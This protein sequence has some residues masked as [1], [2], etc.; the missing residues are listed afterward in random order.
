MDSLEYGIHLTNEGN[1]RVAEVIDSTLFGTASQRDEAQLET[2]RSAVLNKNLRWFNRYRATDGYSTYGQRAFLKFVDD[3]TNYEVMQHE[4][5]MLDVMT[6][7]RD[8]G[9][10]AAAQ[11]RDYAIDDSNVPA[12]IK[13]TSNVGGGSRSSSAAKEGS[14]KYLGG[15]EAIGK[16]KVAKGMRVNLFAS[17]EQFPEL[18]NPVQSAVDTNGRLWVAAWTTYPHWHP[19]KPLNDKLEIFPD[20]DGD[21]KADRCIVFAD[22]LHN[23]TGFE[24]WNGGVLVAN[25]PN[26][27]FLKEIGR[28]S[29]R[30]RV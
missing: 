3:Q 29:C 25:A 9:I 10:W 18:I 6:A 4:L 14:L 16:M 21:G 11:G 7:N 13:V 15:E 22:E 2:V 12:P 27:L 26:I 24:F 30:E 17:E 20:E 28:A 23:P 5:N 1:R 19:N 8:K